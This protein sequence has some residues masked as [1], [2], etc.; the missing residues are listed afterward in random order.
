[1][2]PR[3]E[4]LET[5][6][7]PGASRM[8]SQVWPFTS[9]SFGQ[10]PLGHGGVPGRRDTQMAESLI[11][12]TCDSEMVPEESR[13]HKSGWSPGSAAGPVL[14]VPTHCPYC[15]ERLAY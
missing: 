12:Q 15:G 5:T 13:P 8:V 7:S 2:P 14:T 10:I 1:M 4:L 6:G 3:L 11:C 9:N